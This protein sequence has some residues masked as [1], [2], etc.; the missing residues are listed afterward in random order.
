MFDSENYSRIHLGTTASCF[1]DDLC[2]G[3]GLN[4][5]ARVYH[6][7]RELI[8][9]QV[10]IE[11][12]Y[13]G[14]GRSRH[15]RKLKHSVLD[16]CT[17]NMAVLSSGHIDFEVSAQSVLRCSAPGCAFFIHYSFVYLM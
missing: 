4:L 5:V 17:G 13:S 2:K 14:N 3:A 9:N 11:T 7:Q 16:T 10:C 6:L 8:T 12:L 1:S 15:G